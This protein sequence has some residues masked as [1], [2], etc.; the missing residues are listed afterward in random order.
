MEE[1]DYLFTGDSI[2]INRM[3]KIIGNFNRTQGWR[4]KSDEIIKVLEDGGNVA[5]VPVFK[6]YL[7]G[8]MIALIHSEASEALEG[9]RK[10]LMDDKLIHRKMVEVELADIFIRVL[11]FADAFGLDLGGAVVEKDEYNH[12]RPDHKLANRMKDGG[13]KF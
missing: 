12:K 11:D 13:K 10:N 4:N 5:L 3:V 1:R 7:A 8:T 2:D 9:L 6:N